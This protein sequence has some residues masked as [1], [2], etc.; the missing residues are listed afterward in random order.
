MKTFGISLFRALCVMSIGILLVS[1]PEQM[2][3]VLI[4]IIGGLFALSGLITFVSYFVSRLSSTGIRPMFPV[5]GVGSLAFGIFLL[6]MPDK[7]IN[8][9]MYVLGG[10]LVFGALSQIFSLVNY[11]KVVPLSWAVFVIPVIV[12]VIGLLVILRPSESAATP[13]FFLGVACIAYGVAEFFNG[14]RLHRGQ[15][16]MA[17]EAAELRAYETAKKEAETVPFEEV[18][19]AEIVDGEVGASEVKDAEIVDGEAGASDVAD[20]EIVEAET[21]DGESA[22]GEI[23]DGD[24]KDTE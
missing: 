3:T 4:Q 21:A 24:T 7:F 17:R 8:I 5:V 12:L 14:L 13:F 15:K 19:D 16:R 23:K 1:N 2:T 6:L 18:K 22:G 10:L 9:L 11:R 20:A